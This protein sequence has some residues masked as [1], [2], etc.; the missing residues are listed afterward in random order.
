M[1]GIQE[2]RV[3]IVG[4]PDELLGGE[5]EGGR[6]SDDALVLLGNTMGG[7]EGGWRRKIQ[8]WIDG[9]RDAERVDIIPYFIVARSA[10]YPSQVS[11]MW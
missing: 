4:V 10:Q 5:E 9:V 11:L 2:W 3:I 8:W 1:I 6:E 7:L